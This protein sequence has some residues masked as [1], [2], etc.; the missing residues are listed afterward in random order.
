[1]ECKMWEMI[2]RMISDRL[3]IYTAIV[4]SIF[5]ALFIAYMRD[6]R[7][8]LWVYSKWDGLLDYIRDK[9]GWRWFDQPEDAW[10]KISPR[11]AKKI[12]ELEDRIKKLE[13]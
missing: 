12:D 4:G 9:F 5:G 6:T 1:M 11:I 8:G 2:E 3:W 13:K 10:R 7:I